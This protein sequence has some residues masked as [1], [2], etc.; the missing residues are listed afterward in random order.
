[1]SDRTGQIIE[2]PVEKIRI[3]EELQNVQGMMPMGD[4]DYYNLKLDIKK[5]GIREPLKGYS[6]SKAVYILAG[7]NR[8]NIAK[9]LGIKKV[10]VELLD[11]LAMNLREQFCIDDNL[12]R[13]H[14]TRAQKSKLIERELEKNPT[15]SDRAI[16]EKFSASPT[17]VGTKRKGLQ[18]LSKLDSSAKRTGKDG[19]TRQIKPIPDKQPQKK[20]TKYSDTELEELALTMKEQYDL[21]S[22][23]IKARFRNTFQHIEQPDIC[24]F[25][26]LNKAAFVEN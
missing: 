10:K 19:K 24:T 1:M 21:A 8:L 25:D 3:S 5:H 23:S 9:E 18:Q 15:R 11:D 13:R 16:A 20:A 26:L 4:T 7:A 22:D 17:T 6:I 2:L 14:L 12:N